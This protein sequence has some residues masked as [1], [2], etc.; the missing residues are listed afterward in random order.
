M[1]YLQAND[2]L[3]IIQGNK[4]KLMRKDHDQNYPVNI[5]IFKNRPTSPSD[6]VDISIRTQHLRQLLLDLDWNEILDDYISEKEVR[7]FL[8]AVQKGFSES[9]SSISLQ[10]AYN[11]AKRVVDGL[12]NYA[13]KQLQDLSKIF[14]SASSA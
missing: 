7:G 4:I 2:N 9:Q 8:E 14:A 11:S 6:V 10:L 1:K 3:L 5:G 12:L 13:Q